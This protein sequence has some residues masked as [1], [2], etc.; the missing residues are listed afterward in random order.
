MAADGLPIEQ[1]IQALAS[2]LDT[3][4]ETMAMKARAGL[5]LT[6]A[7]KDLS[8]DLRAHID[9]AGSAVHIRPA[10]PGDAEASTIRLALTTITRPMIEENTR[11]LASEPGE[12]T[13]R[14]AL[15]DDMTE[16]DQRRLQWAGI[17]SVSQLRDVQRSAG[18]EAIERVAHLP[19][20][21]LR[22]ALEHSSRPRIRRVVADPAI[23]GEPPVLRIQGDRLLSDA[24]ARVRVG[25]AEAR[26]R[27]AG[28]QEIVVEAP[29]GAL[30][31][32]LEVETAPGVVGQ[33]E[34]DARPGPAD[35]QTP[36]P[37]RG[38]AS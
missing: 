8:V 29:N 9:M 4:Q 13:L 6:F 5:P 37:P 32:S 14:E 31:G 34:F 11:P 28:P 1:F 25:G 17:R 27:L 7:V 21:R 22:Q 15:G 2:Q 26:V 35:D 38:G 10:G 23:V 18:A 36:Y 19:I 20:D 3:V 30:S 12:P 33:V 24:P 16:E